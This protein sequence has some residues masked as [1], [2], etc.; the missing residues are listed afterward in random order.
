MTSPQRRK[1]VKTYSEAANQS[2]ASNGLASHALKKRAIF[3]CLAVALMTMAFVPIAQ[4][5]WST[6]PAFLSAYHTLLI[7]AYFISAYIIFGFYEANHSLALLYLFG[8]CCYT[9]VIQVVQFLAFPKLFLENGALIGGSQTTV[10]LWC[11]WHAGLATSI[12]LYAVSEWLWP[13]YVVKHPGRIATLCWT[14]LLLL[15]TASVLSVTLFHDQMPPLEING[16]FSR[17]TTTGIAPAIQAIIVFTLLLL[18]RATHF[19]SELHVWLGVALTALLFDNAITMIGGSF[20]SVGW[21]IGR[22]NALISACVVLLVYLVEINRVYLTTVRSAHRLE[23]SN[24]LLTVKVDQ[25]RLDQLTGLPRRELFI[26][27]VAEQYAANRGNGTIVAVLFI[28]LDGFKHVN[29]TLGHDHGDVVL[30]KTADVLRSVLRDDDIAARM[31]GDEFVVCLFAPFSAV[32]AI[33]ID[34]AGRIVSMVSDIGSGI[35]CSIGVSLCSVDSLD[36][37]TALRHA[38]QAMYEAKKLG[39]NNFVIHGQPLLR[40]LHNI[41][42]NSVVHLV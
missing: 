16:D 11:F 41:K 28:D 38:D 6:I 18:W 25:A 42:K 34:V 13:G 39:K 33:M 15:I 14:L 20:L 35:G 29:D 2:I 1:I 3:I 36:I 10:W 31:G 23:K 40:K 17:I 4:E 21:Y 9:A 7:T 5:N 24:A 27:R 22:F 32:Q 12:F 37:E 19:R 30:I 26:D 8:G